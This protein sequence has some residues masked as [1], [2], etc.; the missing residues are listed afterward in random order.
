VI[1]AL[2]VATGAAAGAASGSRRSSWARS[3][4]SRATV[5]PVPARDCS[6]R[7]RRG[8][9]LAITAAADVDVGELRD[10]HRHSLT[11]PRWPRPAADWN[12]AARTLTL[13]RIE[14]LAMLARDLDQET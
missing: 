1:V 5:C 7:L 3:S 4:T 9:A 10:Q 12:A 14:P 8:E 6:P 13:R 2:H 11:R